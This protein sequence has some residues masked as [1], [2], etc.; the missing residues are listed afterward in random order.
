M[1]AWILEIEAILAVPD[2][3]LKEKLMADGRALTLRPC[4]ATMTANP[5]LGGDPDVRG[6]SDGD[7]RR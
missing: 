5:I 4:T 7:G 3:P 1:Q 2:R 6:P